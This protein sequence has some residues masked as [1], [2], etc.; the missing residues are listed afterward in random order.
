MKLVFLVI[1]LCIIFSRTAFS[2]GFQQSQMG[3]MPNAVPAN[4]QKQAAIL[5]SQTQDGSSTMSS[6]GQYNTEN[7][8]NLLLPGDLLIITIFL[9]IHTLIENKYLVVRLPMILR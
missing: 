1:L 7:R 2:I 6:L 8:N 9:H 4:M 5:S 3:A